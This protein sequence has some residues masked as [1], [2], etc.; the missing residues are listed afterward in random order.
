VNLLALVEHI[1]KIASRILL[2]NF[3][4]FN[5]VECGLQPAGQARQAI[6]LFPAIGLLHAFERVAESVDGIADGVRELGV[7]QQKFKDAVVA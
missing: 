5:E 6:G 1:V 3:P 7:Q 2:E 4:D